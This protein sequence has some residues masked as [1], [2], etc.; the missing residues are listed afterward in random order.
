MA[1]SALFLFLRKKH[2]IFSI[3]SNVGRH[4]IG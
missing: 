4:L 2:Y 1:P 3:F